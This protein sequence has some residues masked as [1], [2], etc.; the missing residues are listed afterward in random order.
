[1]CHLT[2]PPPPP[3]TLNP[4]LTPTIEAVLLRAL[5]KDPADR[6]PTGATLAQAL[7][8]AMTAGGGHG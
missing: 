8:I 6:Y 2:E 3:R 5:A 7:T 1:M 4:A